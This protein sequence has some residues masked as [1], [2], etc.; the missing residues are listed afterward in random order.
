MKIR[1][2]EIEFGSAD[3][4][5]TSSFYQDIFGLEPAIQ[6]EGLIVLDAGIKG[7]DFNL[8]NH[9]P[10]GVVVISFLTDDL[11]EAEERLK[12][13]G[14]PYQGPSLS[15]LGMTCIQ[16]TNPDGQLIK[17]NTPGSESPD[18]LQV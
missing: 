14:I 10:K 13:A 5:K 12:K 1:L 16:F 8:S 9:F 6:Q 3:V 2:H 15:H 4:E 7:L 11:T 18:W 17:V